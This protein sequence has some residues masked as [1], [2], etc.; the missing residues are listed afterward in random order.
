MSFGVNNSGCRSKPPAVTGSRD[1][2]S[3]LSTLISY[4]SHLDTELIFNKFKTGNIRHI[5]IC[6]SESA[7]ML[8][9]GSRDKPV[10][11]VAVHIKTPRTG[12]NLRRYGEE[13]KTRT[14]ER[15]LKSR[16]H[17]LRECNPLLVNVPPDKDM[18]IN[19]YHF[20]AHSSWNGPMM[21]PLTDPL[22]Y[23]SGSTALS[24][25]RLKPGGHG[26]YSASLI[27]AL[28]VMVSNHSGLNTPFSCANSARLSGKL[29]TSVTIAL[30][31]KL[32]Y[33]P[34]STGGF[35]HFNIKTFYRQGE[36]K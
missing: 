27:S 2:V 1:E 28:R 31:P 15:S 36:N 35:N 23:I 29:K 24:Q 25:R 19:N 4:L 16:T 32:I 17:R 26:S 13:F 9:S 3:R 14:A 33:A 11:R 18:S 34:S 10:R 12:G 21:S 6:R 7:V 5:T 8:N 30:L 20:A 22:L